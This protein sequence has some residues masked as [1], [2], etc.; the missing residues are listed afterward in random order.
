MSMLKAMLN[1]AP[2]AAVILLVLLVIYF[3]IATPTESAAIG[4]VGMAIL[5]LLYKRMTLKGIFRAS[6]DGIR[7]GAFI[8]LIF[9]AALVFGHIAVR[10]GVAA[11][12]SEAV[13]GAGL[14]KYTVL[15][16]ILGILIFLGC[17][18]DPIPIILTTMPILYPLALAAGFNPIYFGVICTMAL[19]T[20]AITPPVGINLFV[21]S[22]I[23]K[24]YVTMAD[25]V[26]GS[27]PFV[28]LYFMAI[29]IV[30]FFPEIIMYLP[31]K[32][33]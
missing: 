10:G 6:A 11:G 2:L 20:A 18:M 29:V 15:L 14:S 1:I 22:G 33:K 8:I 7:I 25:I 32:M 28:L 12:I 21:L 27:A 5:A 17:F 9:L 4:C 26:K 23:G 3:G 13:L 30:A 16:I 19:E 31:N 24:E